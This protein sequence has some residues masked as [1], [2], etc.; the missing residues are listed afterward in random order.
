MG[1]KRSEDLE[2]SKK[3]FEVTLVVYHW[4]RTFPSEER[5]ALALQMRRAAASIPANIAEGFARRKPNDKARFYN[6]AEASAEELSV[7]IRIASALGYVGLPSDLAEKVKATARM[8]RRLTD[9]TLS[10]Y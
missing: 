3:G 9:V 6:I 8:L 2:V 10:G 7:F 1:I 4:T 5:F